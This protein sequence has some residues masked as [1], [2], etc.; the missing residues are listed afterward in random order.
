M[1]EFVAPLEREYFV[2]TLTACNN[3]ITKMNTMMGYPNEETK[4]MRYS[5]P[6]EHGTDKGVYIVP[7][8]SVYAPKLNGYSSLEMMEGEMTPT[9]LSKKTTLSTLKT[10]GAFEIEVQ[11]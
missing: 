4:T 2:G 10:Q 5:I 3:F 8:K 7:L 9:Q 11:L 1:A 6:R